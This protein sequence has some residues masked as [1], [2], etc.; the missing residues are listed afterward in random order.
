[1][2]THAI[3][4]FGLLIAEVVHLLHQI[5]P[6]NQ[7][8]GPTPRYREGCRVRLLRPGHEGWK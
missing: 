2:L 1:M 4:E 6:L 5:T 3:L 7:P 8:S